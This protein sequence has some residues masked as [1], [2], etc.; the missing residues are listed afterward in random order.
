MRKIRLPLM[1]PLAIAAM[2]LTTIIAYTVYHD[3]RSQWSK[4]PLA[5]GVVVLD[6]MDPM[7][8]HYRVVF[9]PGGGD[10]NIAVRYDYESRTG[11]MAYIAWNK[12]EAARLLHTGATK[13]WVIVNFNGPQPR[14]AFE[15][16]V[17]DY[18]MEV[19]EY[20]MRAVEP[21]TPLV[22]EGNRVAVIGAPHNGAL[23]PDDLFNTMLRNVT[24]ERGAL[25]KGW[26]TVRG[27]V[28]REGF[29]KLQ[30]DPRVA[31]VEVIETIGR[32]ALLTNRDKLVG[33]DPQ[34]LQALEVDAPY[35]RIQIDGPPLYWKLEDF[36]LVPKD[37]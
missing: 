8:I 15:Q 21:P 36:E 9:G 14:E 22:P 12:N 20:S 3:R 18:H 2:L 34:L 10:V 35:S 28:D 19:I 33:A 5:D 25:F 37:S 24:G 13:F 31:V 7:G 6:R 26:I 16:F 29:Q 4:A 17:K 32:Q 23:I 11:V 30:S 27:R 1:L